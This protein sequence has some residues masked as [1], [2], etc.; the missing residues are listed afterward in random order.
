MFCYTLE[1]DDKS[2]NL[3]TI[4]TPYDKFQYCRMAM[5]LKP[6]P[7]IAQATIEEILRDLDV[8]AYIDDVGIFYQHLGGPSESTR[9]CSSMTTR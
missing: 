4:V 5:G 8:D 7:D 9:S 1:L 3:C 2:K 6:A